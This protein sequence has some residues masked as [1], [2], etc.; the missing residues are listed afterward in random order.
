MPDQ[1]TEVSRTG[2]G[3]NILSSIAGIGIG[4]IMFIASF[5]VLWSNE[6]RVNLGKVAAASIAVAPA[7]DAP[8]AEGKL[9]ALSGPV[10]AD[11]PVGDPEYLKP[12]AYLAL[13]RNV[14][15]YS[16][17]EEKETKEEKKTGGS[18]ETKTTYTY[19]KAWTD[20]P[21]ETGDFRYPQGH[22][23]PVLT[24]RGRTF[25]AGRAVIGRYGFNPAD[26]SLPE[27]DPVDL[28]GSIATPPPNG[29]LT[30]DYLYL[31]RGSLDSP[32]L[33]DVRISFSSVN[34]GID[35]TLLG[36]K[37]GTSVTAYYHKGKSRLFRLFRG[38]RDD[39][40]AALKTEH[41]IMGWI[42]RIVG[43]LLMWIGMTLVLAPIGAVLDVL[44]F[45]G[46]I[47]RSFIGCATF[48]VALVLS[49][50]T[51]IVAL[52]AHNIIALAVC[53]AAAVA[54]IFLLP[55]RRRAAGPAN[56]P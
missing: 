21:A 51:I 43:F 6:G 23:N 5:I 13:T 2:W 32:Q 35:A 47:G 55:R 28:S 36:K 54:L 9:V 4:I 16:W 48:V 38:T 45:L 7:S 15:M 56:Q 30:G 19:K 1:F 33:G 37:Q 53:I 27:A 44:P 25:T 26:A 31:G 49:A 24:I 29:R 39:A 41:K 20:D 11:A 52:I 46:S 50:I 18:T 10:F 40:I 42:L 22:E 8:A 3:K 17:V 12:G 14:E 34:A